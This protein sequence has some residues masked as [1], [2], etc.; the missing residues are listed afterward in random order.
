LRS[1]RPPFLIHLTGHPSP[2][3]AI[4]TWGASEKK[5]WTDSSFRHGLSQL[6]ALELRSETCFELM[7]D[8]EALHVASKSAIPLDNLVNVRIFIEYHTHSPILFHN[9]SGCIHV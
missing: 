6:P 1:T 2:P 9:A 7:D 8:V 3:G 4:S 5:E